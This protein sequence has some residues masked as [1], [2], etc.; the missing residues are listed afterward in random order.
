MKIYQEI[1]DLEILAGDTPPQIH[2]TVTGTS[3]T[4]LT[5]AAR[6]IPA[7]APNTTIRTITCSAAEDGFNV[8]LASTDT[9]GLDGVYYLDVTISGTNVQYKRLRGTLI[10]RKSAGGA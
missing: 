9:I 2:I 7:R 5:A 6:I 8:Q 3:L 10:V 4:G 1:P